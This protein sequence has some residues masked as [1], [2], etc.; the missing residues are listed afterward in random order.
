MLFGTGA[1]AGMTE[2]KPVGSD[3]AIVSMSQQGKGPIS[4]R[5]LDAISIQEFVQQGGVNKPAIGG[6]PLRREDLAQ[7]G[8]D[9]QRY[10]NGAVGMA[11]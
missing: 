1:L 8:R 10:Y 6:D 11:R 5:S 4:H 7:Q 2:E 3:K 9:E